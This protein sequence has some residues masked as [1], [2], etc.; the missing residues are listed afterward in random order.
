LSGEEER[1]RKKSVKKGKA[2]FIKEGT[3]FGRSLLVSCLN[4]SGNCDR[5]SCRLKGRKKEKRG[6][7]FVGTGYYFTLSLCK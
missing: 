2:T 3:S 5:F 1:H 6:R 7:D 4:F